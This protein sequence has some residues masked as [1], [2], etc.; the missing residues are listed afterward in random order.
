MKFRKLKY[1]DLNNVSAKSKSFLI[2]L[3]QINVQEQQLI[4]EQYVII[5]LLQ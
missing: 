3:D 5:W 4:V 2:T 1:N